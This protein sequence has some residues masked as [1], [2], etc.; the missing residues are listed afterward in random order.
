MKLIALEIV[1]NV[2]KVF[3][4]QG[5]HIKYRTVIIYIVTTKILKL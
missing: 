3:P 2:N 5:S 1:E 4:H